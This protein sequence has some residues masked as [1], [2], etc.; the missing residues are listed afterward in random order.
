MGA[1]STDLSSLAP[2]RD[3]TL[4]YRPVS[5][6]S[7]VAGSSGCQL[8]IFS[9]GHYDAADRERVGFAKA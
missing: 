2:L 1:P 7:L 3:D 5:V 6:R 9:L 4:T 8:L